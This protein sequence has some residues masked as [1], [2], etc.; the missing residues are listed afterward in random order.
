MRR[1]VI[2]GLGT[3]NSLGMSVSETFPRILAGESGVGLIE[4]FDTTDLTAKI[5]GMV[6]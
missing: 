4:S 5:G 1:V 3:V 6:R 2:T